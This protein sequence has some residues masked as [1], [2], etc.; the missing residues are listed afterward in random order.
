M[1]TFLQDLKYALRLQRRSVGFTAVAVFT[2][3]L[4]I[5]AST[6]VFSVVNAI[7]LKPLQY[8]ESERIVMPWRLAPVGLNLGYDIIPWGMRHFRI[9]ADGAK[10]FEYLGA[11]KT[12][13]FNLT[14]SGDPALLE[15]LRV[16]AGFFPSLGVK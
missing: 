8:P 13:S 1:E 14:G 5:G 2:I 12:A 15:G 4:G 3:A 7:L 11:F 9:I 16:S 10:T 6:A